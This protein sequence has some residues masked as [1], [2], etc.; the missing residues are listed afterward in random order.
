MKA[1]RISEGFFIKYNCN[2]KMKRTTNQSFNLYVTKC[3]N[4][5]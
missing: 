1:L 2:E 4:Q 3:P 5:F